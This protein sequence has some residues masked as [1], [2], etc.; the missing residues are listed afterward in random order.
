MSYQG[1]LY[2]AG[3]Y[4]ESCIDNITQALSKM[5]GQ[6]VSLDVE[7]DASLI[8]GFRAIVDG[9]LYDASLLT[10]CKQIRRHLT[11]QS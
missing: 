11:R 7:E 2:I 6:P 10:Q 3:P 8:G 9:K 4:D 5:L 1:K